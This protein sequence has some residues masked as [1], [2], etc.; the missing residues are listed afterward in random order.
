MLVFGCERCGGIKRLNIATV[1]TVC[2][3]E[4]GPSAEQV[5]LVLP[6]TAQGGT[7]DDLRGDLSEGRTINYLIKF[8]GVAIWLM[9][10]VIPDDFCSSFFL[11]GPQLAWPNDQAKAVLQG[12]IAA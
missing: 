9:L 1:R 8:G 7:V 4:V 5:R 10:L 6:S 11:M 3:I 12:E 2:H